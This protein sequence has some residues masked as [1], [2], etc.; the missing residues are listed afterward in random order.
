MI[1]ENDKNNILKI[2]KKLNKKGMTII[3]VVHDLKES[4]YSERLLVLSDGVIVLDGSP[5]KVMEYDKI[6]NKLN[7]M[8]AF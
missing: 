1:D 5:L 7:K 3:N 2:L 8:L 4:Y 6:L